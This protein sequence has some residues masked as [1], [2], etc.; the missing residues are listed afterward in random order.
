MT[1]E[2]QRLWCDLLAKL[3]HKESAHTERRSDNFL[4]VKLSK[5]LTGNND[6][7]DRS[8]EVLRAVS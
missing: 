5:S 8:R 2:V 7:A 3:N 6:W 1:E 4:I